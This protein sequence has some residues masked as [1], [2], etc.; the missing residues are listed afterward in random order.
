[1]NRRAPICL[2]SA[3]P[4]PGA[5]PR[6]PA[7]RVVRRQCR[8]QA[9]CPRHRIRLARAATP[10]HGSTVSCAELILE[11]RRF[12]CFD[13][14]LFGL[15]RQR[16]APRWPRRWPGHSGRLRPLR[17]CRRRAEPPRQSL[18]AMPSRSAADQ[19]PRPDQ[20]R[21][22]P[23]LHGASRRRVWRIAVGGFENR[24]AA[25]FIRSSGRVRPC[26]PSATTSCTH[27]CHLEFGRNRQ[28][29]GRMT[30]ARFHLSF[31]K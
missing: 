12:Q 20:L 29:R 22:R 18:R 14:G 7:L 5:L 23:S 2:C 4:Q 13:R 26:R 30:R 24:P 6:V 16:P 10:L 15:A 8:S 17:H 3:P 31:C 19:A 11:S 28:R 27:R 21:H 1:M 25:P 9:G